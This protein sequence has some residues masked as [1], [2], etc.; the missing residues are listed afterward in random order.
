MSKGPSGQVPEG[1]DRAGQLPTR[2]PILQRTRPLLP[3]ATDRLA[4]HLTVRT[5]ALV[6]RCASGA[7]KRRG[8]SGSPRVVPLSA[9]RAPRSP[10]A[11]EV[12]AFAEQSMEHEPFAAV[13]VWA[14]G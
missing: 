12:D 14:V 7:S 10:R 13:R 3:D 4:A 6:L 1:N 2:V 11:V 5:G 8:G 9:G